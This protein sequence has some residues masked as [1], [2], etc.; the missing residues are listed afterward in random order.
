MNI[1]L[2]ILLSPFSILYGIVTWVRNILYDWGIL[3]STPFATKVICVGNINTGGTGKSPMIEYL[4]R[5][6]QGEKM[7]VATLSRGYGRNTKGFILA[8]DTS[9][10]LSIGDE[11]QQFFQKFQEI[12][13]AVCEN[14]LEGIQNLMRRTPKP[15]MILL[16]DAFQ[17]RRIKAGLNILLS[18]YGNLYV[19]DSMLP[20]G[21]LREYGCGAKRANLIIITKSPEKLTE[22]DKEPIIRK[23]APQ[24]HQQVLFSF[25]GYGN[26]IG[27]NDSHDVLD[28]D[29][30][31]VSDIFLF[32]GI[33]N[34]QPLYSYLSER[35][36]NL[37][38]LSFSDHHH[39]T[40]TDIHKISEKFRTI[41]S[42]NKIIITTEKDFVRLSHHHELNLLTSFPIFYI[43]VKMDFD[44]T[45]KHKLD[46]IL[47]NYAR[48]N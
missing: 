18:E 47:I 46:Q 23:I 17:H 42:E 36:A 10:A 37:H 15:D 5:F 20:S 41:A 11:P 39:Y 14:R 38:T 43:P 19:Y 13:V 27:F 32:T 25:I 44:S 1:L 31:K 7:K 30:L 2:K 3:K 34:P 45:D 22:A 26:P 6:F 12:D 29:S 24:E 48:K 28:M 8:D 9:A 16:D 4:I 40:A 35:C 33:A 21:R